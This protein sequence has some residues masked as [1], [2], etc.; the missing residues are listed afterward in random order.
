MKP[1]ARKVAHGGLGLGLGRANRQT[2]ASGKPWPCNLSDH[3]CIHTRST[4]HEIRKAESTVMYTKHRAPS[5]IVIRAVRD[6]SLTPVGRAQPVP[7]VGSDLRR[8]RTKKNGRVS[9]N[10][11][12]L[13]AM[14]RAR[15]T[16]MAKLVM[17]YMLDEACCKNLKDLMRPSRFSSAQHT[18]IMNDSAMKTS[19]CSRPLRETNRTIARTVRGWLT[20]VGMRGE[21]RKE[22]GHPRN[23]A[24]LFTR[25]AHRNNDELSLLSI[26]KA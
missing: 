17:A 20:E 3:I 8:A 15:L 1:A 18:E 4:L 23:M 9:N 10:C 6:A 22:S 14:M 21:E 11:I 12:L 25:E 5:R 26:D 24:D 7:T 19:W 2:H 16:Q 13:T